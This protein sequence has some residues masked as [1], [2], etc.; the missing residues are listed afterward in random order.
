LS[1]VTAFGQVTVQDGG[2]RPLRRLKRAG[3]NVLGHGVDP[4]GVIATAIWPDLGVHAVGAATHQQGVAVAQLLE[5]DGIGFVIDEVEM[6]AVHVVDH[7]VEAD[8][9]RVDNLSHGD[10]LLR[11]L[12]S[13]VAAGLCPGR[14]GAWQHTGHV[15]TT[16]CEGNGCAPLTS[17]A[18][19]GPDD[20]IQFDRR[21]QDQF[22]L[23][24]RPPTGGLLVRPACLPGVRVHPVAELAV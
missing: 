12:L 15:G 10:L 14:A 24:G 3:R 22:R 13:R 11:V 8:E 17:L 7:A 4:V 5:S 19:I 20:K 1:L 9:G 2:V 6:P 18:R 23:T 16:P 21:K